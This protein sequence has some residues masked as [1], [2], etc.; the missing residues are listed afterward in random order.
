M[1]PPFVRDPYNYDLA[2]ASDESAVVNDQPSMTIQEQAEDADINIIVA[3]FG[4]TQQFPENPRMP[5]YGDFTGITDY[6]T[7]LEAVTEA[8]NQFM[9]L[10]PNV[11]FS[12]A[13]DPQRLLEFAD[14]NG[15]DTKEML[16]QV[17]ISEALP[18]IPEGP[19]VTNPAA[20]LPKAE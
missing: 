5:V 2:Q 1:K 4:I 10:P 16:R 12:L 6:R 14:A 15:N 18:P 11:R 3:R 9:A 17:G 13:N 19:S 7:A 20:N 8:Q